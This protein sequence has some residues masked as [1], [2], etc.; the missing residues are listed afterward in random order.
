MSF[1]IDSDVLS[2]PTR[3]KPDAQ[4]LEW[5]E[6]NRSEV[7]TSSHVIG[8][9]QAGIESLAEGAKKRK[10]QSWLGRLINAME[11]RILNFNVSVAIVWGK[12]EAEFEKKGCRMPARDSFIAATARRH[13]LTI[14]TR[15]V[16]DFDRPGLKVFNPYTRDD[17]D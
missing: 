10:L 12:Q 7:Y 8:E 5:L 14:V 6:A 1:L 13:N 9:L 2:E 17:A 16:G 4:V 3:A 11:G 15:N